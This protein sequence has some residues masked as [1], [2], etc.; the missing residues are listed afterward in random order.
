MNLP[1]VLA[2]FIGDFLFQ[3]DW[4]A[5][6][7]KNSTFTCTIHVLFYMIPFLMVEL[8]WI[9]FAL[10]AVQ[11]WVQDRSIFISWYCRKFGIFQSELKQNTLPWGHFVVDQIFHFIWMWIVMSYF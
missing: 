9:Q 3:T 2:H 10:I 1:W 5:R 4:M 11:H 8:S 7:K 6:G